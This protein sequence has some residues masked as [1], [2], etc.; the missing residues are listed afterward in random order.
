MKYHL[1]LAPGL[2]RSSSIAICVLTTGLS[3]LLSFTLDQQFN[4][5]P[6]KG[7]LNKF[8][9]NST[10]LWKD[11]VSANRYFLTKKKNQNNLFVKEVF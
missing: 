5:E 7:F 10:F 9:L 11:L 2:A 3:L 8:C 6:K 1:G 4:P